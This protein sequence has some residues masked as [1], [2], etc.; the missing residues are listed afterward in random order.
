MNGKK[1]TLK[2]KTGTDLSFASTLFG[3]RNLINHWYHSICTQE[4]KH[5][6]YTIPPSLPTFPHVH[7]FLFSSQQPLMA[8]CLNGTTRWQGESEDETL[9]HAKPRADRNDRPVEQPPAIQSTTSLSLPHDLPSTIVRPSK[10]CLF[11]GFTASGFRVFGSSKG[12][13][14]SPCRIDP[15]GVAPL[16]CFAF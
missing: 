5:L 6:I 13:G 10:L 16:A 12:K 4:K 3:A 2:K 15:R 14:S 7:V 8:V 1:G 9:L 11:R